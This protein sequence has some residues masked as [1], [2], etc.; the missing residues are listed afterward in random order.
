MR[1]LMTNLFFMF[2]TL[3]LADRLITEN[4]H[5]EYASAKYLQSEINTEFIMS[6]EQ[7]KQIDGFENLYEIS[8]EGRVLSI[9]SSKVLKNNISAKG[10]YI[11]RLPKKTCYVH[12]LVWDA[13]GIEPRNGHILQIDHKDNDKRNNRIENLQLLTTRQNVGKGYQANGKKLPTGVQYRERCTQR[14]Y[15]SL[16]TVNNKSIHL[17]H[18]T[19]PE[20]ARSKYLE[21]VELC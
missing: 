3:I 9:R 1:L 7:W 8:N 11:V 6:T 17:G 10:Y 12:H 20:E 18:Y 14:P 4:I 13:F 21:A 19:N 15:E 16:I 2:I 5:S